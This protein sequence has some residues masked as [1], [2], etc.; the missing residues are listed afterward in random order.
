LGGHDRGGGLT[1]RGAVALEWGTTDSQSRAA[2]AI[3]VHHGVVTATVKLPALLDT[4]VLLAHELQHVIEQT[5]GL[6]LSAEAKRRV[7]NFDD[8]WLIEVDEAGAGKLIT[9]VVFDL[10]LRGQRK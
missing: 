5:R 9:H 6:D 3:G 2:T 4:V 8:L 7:R 10:T 1:H